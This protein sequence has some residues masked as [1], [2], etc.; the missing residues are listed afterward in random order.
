MR[1]RRR[2]ACVLR[3]RTA[4][5]SKRGSLV[6]LAQTR[7]RSST[8][9]EHSSWICSG[10]PRMRC[11]CHACAMPC[12]YLQRQR[13]ADRRVHAAQ[14]LGVRCDARTEWLAR[15]RRAC[16]M[17]KGAAES[18]PICGGPWR[19][20][21]LG[22]CERLPHDV[23]GRALAHRPIDDIVL[24]CNDM[25]HDAALRHRERSVRNGSR[26][27]DSRSGHQSAKAFAAYLAHQERS[28]QQHT[29]PY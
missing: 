9:L 20:A 8:H 2:D 6:R 23:G 13:R 26:L 25:A 18:T 17:R 28:Q 21:W 7:Y 22:H 10:R 3:A 4:S 29:S 5:S 12:A 19:R 27:E 16:H 11:Q 14:S 24:A 15:R 1:W